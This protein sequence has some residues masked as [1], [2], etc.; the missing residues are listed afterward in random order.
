MRT[1]VALWTKRFIYMELIETPGYMTVCQV[2]GQ[3]SYSDPAS[4]AQLWFH[5]SF[6]YGEFA[7]FAWARREFR[8][9]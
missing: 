6:K 4:P 2:F 8:I 3:S 7:P 1:F 5:R 9:P